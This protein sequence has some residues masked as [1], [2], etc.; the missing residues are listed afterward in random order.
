MD[1]TSDGAATATGAVTFTF[2]FGDDV[3]G[4]VVGGISLSGHS[5]PGSIVGTLG[6]SGAV[7]TLEVTPPS[8]DDGTISVS[9]LMDAATSDLGGAGNVAASATQAYDTSAPVFDSGATAMF[10]VGVAT[11]V[12][13]YTA[14][15]NDNSTVTYSFGSGGDESLFSIHNAT[16]IVRYL[17]V[18]DSA[19]VHNISIIAT[20]AAGNDSTPQPVAITVGAR[21]TLDITSDGAATA[22]GAVTFTFRFG[23]D[24]SGFVVGDISLSGHS[25]PG[26]IVGTLGGSGAVYTLEVT[27][28]SNDDGTISVSVLMDAATSDLGGAGNVAASA[29]QA[30]DTSAP[31]FDSGATAM[32]GV[33]VATT[34]AVY[35]ANANDNSTVTYSFG[36]GG[37]ESL[38]S[39]HNATGIV[40][41]L[42]VRDSAV[43][44][45]ISIIATDAAGNDST[46]QPVAITV[47]ESSLSYSGSFTETDMND[48]TVTG[49]IIATLTGDTF[50]GDTFAAADVIANGSSVSVTSTLPTGLT[51][52]F[53]RTNDTTVTLTLTGA[54][55]PHGHLNDVSDLTITFTEAA[56]VHANVAGIIANLVHDSGMIDFSDTFL[57]Y[58][59]TFTEAALND[60]SVDGS[61]T[62]TLDND[63]FNGTNGGVLDMTAV[64]ATNV[65]PGLTAVFTRTSET[66]VTL[67]LSGT[68]DAHVTDV[69][70]LTITFN[71]AAFASGD[72]AT[73]ANP[74]YA[75]GEI[76]FR[77]ASTL[78]YA[79]TFTESTANDGSITNS[80][81]SSIT[82]ELTGDTFFGTNGDILDATVV[83]ADNVPAGLTAVFTRTS[84]TIVTLTLDGNATDHE[85]DNNVDT[86]TITFTDTAFVRENAATI[87]ASTYATGEIY[88]R[89]ASTLVYAGTFTESTVNDGSVTGSITA[90]LVG[91]TFAE[92]GVIS[93]GTSVTATATN[94]PAGLTAVF[95]RTSAT[96]ITL[97]LDG[98]AGDHEHVNDV[99]DLTITFTDTAFA[100]EN[101][102]TIAASTY[103]TG[104]IDFEDAS[105]LTYAG[106]FTETSANDGTVTGSSITATLVGDTFAAQTVISNGT[107]VTATATNFPAG[108]TAVFT[109]TSDT[110][111]TLTLTGTAGAHLHDQRCG[112]ADHHLHR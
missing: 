67:T 49:S 9:V 73:V 34:V 64:T 104:E 108:L 46:P 11:T 65:P 77:V 95:T 112:R 16:G 4:F 106:R 74:I 91:D 8:N 99:D 56:F 24:V 81:I 100:Q 45:N 78:V 12:A 57:T 30:Y 29:T 42:A 83:E 31:V 1:I 70:D 75:T 13:V 85:V 86:L 90:T 36:S 43:V 93:N 38:F 84:D 2:R 68:A 35:T 92:Q 111:V 14:N 6:G 94:F 76:D 55:D 39:I 51:A 27:P 59:G 88:F 44:H 52:V 26:S 96:V 61:I 107:S 25:G 72:V 47:D 5:G 33:G 105:T 97:T 21:P 53:I 62:A 17:A 50:T 32:F 3:S 98:T 7:Y 28:P 66:I 101:A 41:Y 82:A 63:T 23:D 20:D 22:T 48:G 109:R 103:S 60:G 18:R 79:G 89:D 40:R 87:A 102:A 19:V 15:A 80:S 110:V 10:G 37:D 69:S 71:G 54:A 58:A